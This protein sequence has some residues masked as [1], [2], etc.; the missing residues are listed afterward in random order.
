MEQEKEYG[1]MRE[2]LGRAS[3]KTA[4]DGLDQKI[5]SGITAYDGKRRKQRQAL[6]SW[7][8]MVA[9]GM[10]VILLV[11]VFGSQVSWNTGGKLTVDDLAGVAVKT[12]DAGRWLADHC[13][14]LL[15][16]ILL[17]FRRRMSNPRI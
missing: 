15:P 16:L 12:G 17:L 10:V 11:R 5:M 9:M 7:L 1:A 3:V 2:L 4:P 14:Y 13:Y 6:S 8:R